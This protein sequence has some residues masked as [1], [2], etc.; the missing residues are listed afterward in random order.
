[1]KQFKAG[2]DYEVRSICDHN[3]IF[4]F[5]VIK[6]TAKSIWI[7]ERSEPVKR[8]SI[9]IYNSEECVKPHGSFSM[10]PILGANDI[11]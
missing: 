9:Y 11:V 2:S 6:R 1:M 3:C 8:K 4:K 7:T 10:A 5:K